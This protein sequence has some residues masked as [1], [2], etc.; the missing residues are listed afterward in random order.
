MQQGSAT[1][2]PRNKVALGPGRSLMDWIRLGNSGIDMSGTE[3][4]IIKVT[5]EELAKHNTK[6]DAWICIRG[7]VY[8]VTRYLE[9]HPGGV[10]E[11]MKGAGIDATSLFDSVHSWVNYDSLLKK[12]LVGTLVSGVV[13]S[14]IFQTPAPSTSFKNNTNNEKQTFPSSVTKFDWY[15]KING[16]VFV[17]H[18][19]QPVR[20]LHLNNKTD[21][22][23]WVYFE[24]IWLGWKLLSKVEWPPS[25]T[26][27]LVKAD[28]SLEIKFRKDILDSWGRLV[29]L[30]PGEKP[31]PPSK[32]QL[33]IVEIN[34]INHNVYIIGLTYVNSVFNYIPLGFH[35]SL[36]ANIKDT[37]VERQYTPISNL[38]TEF[39]FD[40][41]LMVKSYP[42]GAFSSWFTSLK[43]ND[44]VT[45][46]MPI[47]SFSPQLLT[48]VTHLVLFAAGTGLTPMV[49]LIQWALQLKKI[50]NV[51]LLFFN[52]SERDIVWREEFNTL[53]RVDTRFTVEH[54]LSQP[55][56]TWSGKQG[57]LTLQM[58]QIF[59]PDFSKEALQPYFVCVCGPI[60]FTQLAERYLQDMNYDAGRYF[61]F[62]G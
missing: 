53:T 5:K 32:A 40:V 37:E 8:N 12:C 11:L 25:V 61:C 46:S 22:E 16:V 39:P 60:A 45:S 26:L 24:E 56:P 28:L 27:V 30:S 52:R 21:G 17:F 47:G 20:K 44:V 7:K 38:L 35:I 3:G 50:I 13:D 43:I 14:Q 19:N 59:I 4:K 34:P 54:I 48:D 1:G 15:Q 49:R 41:T 51:K 33:K 62:R 57:Y 31:P 58:M 6:D 10:V 55:D 18:L 29:T 23:L 42:E 9:F 2:N 36:S